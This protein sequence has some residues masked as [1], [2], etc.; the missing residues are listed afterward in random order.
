M[1][2][3]A[4]CVPVALQLCKR[5]RRQQPALHAAAEREQRRARRV[6]FDLQLAGAVLNRQ[7]L[8]GHKEISV[9]NALALLCEE[10]KGREECA[11]SSDM[12]AAVLEAY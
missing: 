8:E 1:L 3:A 9:R 5:L 7:L 4:A 11:W 2:R 12:A 10:S 6:R